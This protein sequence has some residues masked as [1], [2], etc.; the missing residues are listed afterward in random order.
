MYIYINVCA[1]LEI[2]GFA[3]PNAN[4]FQSKCELLPP[5]DS[6]CVRIN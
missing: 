3:S 4:Q 2:G 5:S 1:K 6:Q